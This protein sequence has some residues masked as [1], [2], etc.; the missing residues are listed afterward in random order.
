MTG[1]YRKGQQKKYEPSEN[2][3]GAV[4]R[5]KSDGAERYIAYSSDVDPQDVDEQWIS[6]GAKK[7]KDLSLWR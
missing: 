2:V 6:I 7:V 5:S 4:V 3:L 1:D